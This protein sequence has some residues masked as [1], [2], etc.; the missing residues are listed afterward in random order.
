[1][2]T[3]DAEGQPRERQYGAVDF[4]DGVPRSAAYTGAGTIFYAGHILGPTYA[5]QGN[6]LLGPAI[7]T[8]M[9]QAFLETPGALADRLMAALQ[10]ANVPAADTRCP[11]RP[12]ISAFVRVARPDD[13]A[14]SFYLDLNVDNTASNQNP[15]ELLQ[16]LFDDWKLAPQASFVAEP[17]AGSDPLEVN[18]DASSSSAVGEA[19]IESYTWTFSDGGTLSGAA[20]SRTFLLPGSY[21]VQLE[22]KDSNNRTRRAQQRIEV[23]FR[24]GSS[25]P[26]LS[27]DIG[28]PGSAGA[29]RLDA[30]CMTTL[31]GGVG[32]RGT[33]D[34][35]HFSYQEVQGDLALSANVRAL[36][37]DAGIAGV[38]VMLRAS[39][40]AGSP[41]AA[42]LLE[43]SLARN[44]VRMRFRTAAG[45]SALSQAGEV[46]SPPAAW[47]RVRR[48]GGSIVGESSA[49]GVAWTRVG[50]ASV[51]LPP[52]LLAGVATSASSSTPGG[53]GAAQ[54]CAITFELAA[55]LRRGDANGSGEVDISDAVHTLGALF[56][57]AVTLP[58]EDAADA[59]DDGVIDIS[60][61]VS[62]LGALFLGTA[63]IPA[64]GPEACGPDPT[65][66][67][68]G[69]C[70]APCR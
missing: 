38:G 42:V 52:T 70:E 68:L 61:A 33:A 60:D 5:I 10:A 44:S 55:V 24:E 12:S 6:I 62:T 31:G 13:P 45:A 49:D 23:A 16:T 34:R 66:D 40:E 63:P 3:H 21:L 48:E 27:A 22:V 2:A 7:L 15:I 41:F 17:A 39:L 36:Y 28:S 53:R 46:L 69:G 37:G 1:M 43:R 11:T 65:E 51:E 19:T 14:T 57:E 18:L 25:G 47:V 8:N 20:V 9:E 54:V 35:G 59:N 58:C 32:F 29:A 50:E 4:R 56:L 64:P 26:W 67:V 30:E